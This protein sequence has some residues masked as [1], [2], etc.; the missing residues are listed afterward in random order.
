MSLEIA[1]IKVIRP[2]KATMGIFSGIL[3]LSIKEHFKVDA[4]CILLLASPSERAWHNSKKEHIT[5][6][7]QFPL[8][9]RLAWTRQPMDDNHRLH[10]NIEKG[11]EQRG[12]D[13]GQ[14]KF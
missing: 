2:L 11:Q 7:C 5:D 3:D 13:E 6:N 12:A 9:P 8:K 10:P 4:G 1:L 14:S